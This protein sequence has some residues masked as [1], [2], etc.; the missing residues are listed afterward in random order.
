MRYRDFVASTSLENLVH[1]N[2]HLYYKFRIDSNTSYVSNYLISLLKRLKFYKEGDKL[3]NVTNKSI[4]IPK[5]LFQPSENKNYDKNS[6]KVKR[7]NKYIS[8]KELGTNRKR[9]LNKIQLL[10]ESDNWDG[11]NPDLNKQLNCLNDKKFKCDYTLKD[12]I[13]W[14][15]D[16]DQWKLLHWQ[17]IVIKVNQHKLATLQ[18]YRV[19]FD[20]FDYEIDNQN[21]LKDVEL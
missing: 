21:E 5:F 8:C 19:V 17:K 16:I 13:V 6:D 14:I 10:N 3:D 1:M 20:D 7:I 9:Q 12:V 4:I 15:K 11:F 2:M 18:D